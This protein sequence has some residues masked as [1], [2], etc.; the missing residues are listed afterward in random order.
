MSLT[1]SV[2]YLLQRNRNKRWR[3]KESICKRWR[4]LL[5]NENGKEVGEI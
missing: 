1:S 3:I 2:S 5:L 4:D